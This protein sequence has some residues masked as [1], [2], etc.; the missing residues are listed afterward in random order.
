[1]SSESAF[2]HSTA[3]AQ[4]FVKSG[5]C[6]FSPDSMAEGGD[7]TPAQWEMTT[8]RVI[9][10]MTSEG[11]DKPSP[12]LLVSTNPTR[13]LIPSFPPKSTVLKTLMRSFATVATKI[14]RHFLLWKKSYDK[15]Q[16]VY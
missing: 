7:K 9:I 6:D 15:L 8:A 12:I 2:F 3:V 13:K 14:K 16:K 11:M 10:I 5:G 1:M 4:A